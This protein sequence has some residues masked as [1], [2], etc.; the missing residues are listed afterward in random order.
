VS[1]VAYVRAN[2]ERDRF[3]RDMAPLFDGYTV[4]LTPVAPGPAPKGLASTGDPRF[5]APWSFIGAP[6]IALP[7]GLGGNGLPL[8]IQLVAGHGREEALL[9]AAVWCE[10]VLGFTARPSVG[11]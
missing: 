1:G 6:S 9:G 3:R 10:R 8:A 2:R 5:C 4:F 7:S 11:R